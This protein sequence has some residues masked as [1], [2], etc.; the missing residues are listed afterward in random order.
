MQM[1]LIIIFLDFE[2]PHIKIR[3]ISY[4]KRFQSIFVNIFITDL[5]L[6]TPLFYSRCNGKQMNFIGGLKKHVERI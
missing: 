1:L 5:L 3:G 4:K 2:N 6:D